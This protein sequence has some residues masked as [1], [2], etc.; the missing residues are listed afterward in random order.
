MW[1]WYRTGRD[2]KL[3]I[4]TTNP[5]KITQAKYYGPTQLYKEFRKPTA[6]KVSTDSYLFHLQNVILHSLILQYMNRSVILT[7]FILLIS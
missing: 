3:K 7:T 1:L 5:K 6:T 2:L 4:S